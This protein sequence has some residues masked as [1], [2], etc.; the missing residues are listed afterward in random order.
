MKKFRLLLLDANIV[1]ELFRLGIWD[2]LLEF[3]DIHLAKSIVGSKTSELRG[4][5]D[6]FIDDLGDR[7][8]IDLEKDIE[9]GKITVFDV[10]PSDL[11]TFR[12][13]FDPTYFEKLDAGE[14]ESLAYLLN[15]KE[16]YQICSADAIVF[17]VLGNISCGKIN[18]SE[19]GISLEEILQKIGLSR[20]LTS[21]FT[22]AFR[23]K[24]TQ[25]GFQE[26]LGG[27]GH[28]NQG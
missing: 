2:Q 9:A 14:T 13:K 4:E 3:C 11:G 8:E 17:R 6:F 25:K 26:H 1:I 22:K 20:K 10:N 24:M 28:H 15:S 5:A 18:R 19:Q 27:M 21:Q 12:A 23:E 16:T 7:H